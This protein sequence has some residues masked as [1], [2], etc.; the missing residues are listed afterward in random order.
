M[1]YNTLTIY[2]LSHPSQSS[3]SLSPSTSPFPSPTHSITPFTPLNF[4][5]SSRPSLTSSSPSPSPSGSTTPFPNHDDHDLGMPTLAQVSR[6]EARLTL[7]PVYLERGDGSAER[8]KGRSE[9]K[10]RTRD[11]R[12]NIRV[13]MSGSVPETGLVSV[14][15]GREE[16]R[17]GDGV[18]GTGSL[19]VEQGMDMGV[20]E[21]YTGMMPMHQR[22]SGGESGLEAKREG[23]KR[24][25]GFFVG[26]VREKD[27]K[28]SKQVYY[29]V[30]K[31]GG[32]RG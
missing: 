16:M 14:P 21:G 12:S 15:R 3:T 13:D 24:R 7:A 9:G 2:P 8:R 29:V 23:G 10:G 27:G 18:S 30:P 20:Q 1:P 4:P 6:S 19:G 31:V 25:N 17:G 28:K 5:S 32:R 11:G 26:W 22:V